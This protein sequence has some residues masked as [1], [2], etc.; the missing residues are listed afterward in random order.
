MMTG[1]SLTIND[2]LDD[3]LAEPDP[4]V[5]MV[6]VEG[7]VPYLSGSLRTRAW[8]AAV[9]VVQANRTAVV[10]RELA[11]FVGPDDLRAAAS[12]DDR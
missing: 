12:A 2:L 6:A 9:A 10:F 3:A 8:V 1:V 11:S 5:R 7:L 4:G